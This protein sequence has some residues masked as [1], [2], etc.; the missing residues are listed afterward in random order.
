MKKWLDKYEDGGKI[1]LN[2]PEYKAPNFYNYKWSQISPEE[3]NFMA[4]AGVGNKTGGIDLFGLTPI[5]KDSRQYW[6][7]MFSG[8]I[9]YNI[10]DKLNISGGA[11]FEKDRIT[12]E[13]GFKYKFQDGGTTSDFE[14]TLKLFTDKAAYDKAMQMYS[15]SLLLNQEMFEGESEAGGAAYDRLTAANKEKPGEDAEELGMSRFPEPRMKPVFKEVYKD[16]EPKEITKVYT[17]KEEYDKA[18]QMYSDSLN[19]YN[20][21]KDFTKEGWATFPYYDSLGEPIPLT[22]KELK[23]LNKDYKKLKESGEDFIETE[24]GLITPHS[25]KDNIF[26]GDTSAEEV[27]SA[28][29]KIPAKYKDL[30]EGRLPVSPSAAVYHAEGLM[31]VLGDKPKQK[32]IYDD[33]AELKAKQ[34]KFSSIGGSV[35]PVVMAEDKDDLRGYKFRTKY[36]EKFVPIE[37]KDTLNKYTNLYG[38]ELPA[39]GKG[40]NVPS[41]S[42]NTYNNWLDKL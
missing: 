12:P 19:T 14:P 3:G 13:V 42:K 23:Q 2:I 28:V 36:G 37:D 20:L 4:G 25:T 39:K 10:N 41:S 11:Q 22:D 33:S 40:G 17:D 1:D 8:K 7:G 21:A 38:L 29:K 35:I 34:E 26:K 15:D 16:V 5:S 18:M 6:P 24:Y 32:P 30:I 9:N 27:P 31:G